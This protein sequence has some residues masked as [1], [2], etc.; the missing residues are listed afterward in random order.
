MRPETLVAWPEGCP[1]Y[2]GKTVATVARRLG[3]HRSTAPKKLHWP[4]SSWILAC[5]SHIR[6]EIVEIV[7]AYGDWSE[8]ERLWIRKIRLVF[9]GGANVTDGGDGAPGNVLS[10]AHRAKL[11]AANFGKKRPPEFCAKMS[12][13]N[14]GKTLSPEH[15]AK[16]AASSKGRIFTAEQRAKLIAHNTGRVYSA[17]TRAKIS[18]GKKGKKHSLESRANMGVHRKGKKHSLESCLKM[19][20]AQKGRIFSDET[21]A[22]MSEAAVRRCQRNGTAVSRPLPPPKIQT[23]NQKVFRYDT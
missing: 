7:P 14:A 2:C 23:H 19:S 17:E 10:A 6:F 4:I 13:I 16:I 11:R 18:V 1:F 22:K 15:R 3:K 12:L 5:G 20:L 8:A 9:P 21:R